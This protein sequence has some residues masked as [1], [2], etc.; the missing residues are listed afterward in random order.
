MGN[1]YELK[2]PVSSSTPCGHVW[3]MQKCNLAVGVGTNLSRWDYC[4]CG[5]ATHSTNDNQWAL[6]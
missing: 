2:Y 5:Y 4:A 1:L 6:D 3:E